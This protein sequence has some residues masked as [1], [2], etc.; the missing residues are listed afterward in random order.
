MRDFLKIDE[1]G[2]FSSDRKPYIIAGPCSVESP[3][4]LFLTA[5]A[6]KSCGV[7]M[8]RGGIWKPRTH[9]GGFEGV[10]SIGLSWMRECADSLGMKCCTEVAG[11]AHVEEALKAGIDMLWIGARTSG[12]PFLLSEIA[13]ALKGT[14]TPVLIKNPL[15]PDIELWMGA[16]ERIWQSGISKAG[17][18]H[19]GFFQ[20]E[21]SIYRNPPL[22]QIPA[23]IKRRIPS[24]PLFCDPSHIAGHRDLVAEVCRKAV[25]LGF[26]GLMIESHIT[27]EKALSDSR[28]QLTP[29]ETGVLL[30]HISTRAEGVFRG[31]NASLIEEYRSSIDRID[32][33]LLELLAERMQIADAIGSVKKSENIPVLQTKRWGE[34]LQK[35]LESAEKKSL[36]TKFVERLFRLIHQF[37]IERQLPSEPPAE[38]KEV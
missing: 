26:E 2:L 37:S 38:K 32:E 8:L 21:R 11:C 24:I 27:P 16:I 3:E 17:I 34:V 4:Q 12:N 14:D 9:P 19:R 1:W 36:D 13:Q 29:E 33:A 20:Y 30:R 15:N 18:I 23:E 31:D 35:A 22:W 10:G 6:L 7:E 5:S 25:N 28:Q